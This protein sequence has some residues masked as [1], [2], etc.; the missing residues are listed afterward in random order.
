MLVGR[1]AGLGI[2]WLWA[3]IWLFLLGRSLLL[4]ARFRKGGW[5]VLGAGPVD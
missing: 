5:V 1:L 3:A 2:G 4:G